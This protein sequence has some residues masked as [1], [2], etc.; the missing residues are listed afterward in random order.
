MVLSVYERTR[1]IGIS[2]AI[3]D[4]ESDILQIF[5]TECTFIGALGGVFGDFFGVIL[6]T[7]MDRVG[8]HLLNHGSELKI[9]AT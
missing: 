9:L 4:S 6:S 3:G 7:L 2:K 5:L 1:E 8:R